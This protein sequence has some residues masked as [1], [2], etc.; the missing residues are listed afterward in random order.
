MSTTKS[1]FTCGKTDVSLKACVCLKVSYC[2]SDCQRSDWKRHKAACPPYVIKDV[3]GKGKGVVATRKLVTGSLIMAEE[4]LILVNTGNASSESK[5]VITKFLNLSE[6][7]KKTV[8]NLYNRYSAEGEY[9]KEGFCQIC[10]YLLCPLL[11][12]EFYPPT[13][14]SANLIQLATPG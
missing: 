5:D 8:M 9:L 3:P 2:N 6:E 12:F 4:P 11:V 7:Q 10:C 13:F 1:C 14:D